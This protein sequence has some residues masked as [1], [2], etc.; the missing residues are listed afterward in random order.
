MIYDS[1]HSRSKSDLVKVIAE[2]PSSS[3]QFST[4]AKDDKRNVDDTN[5]DDT[6]VDKTN[7]YKKN[8]ENS[9]NVAATS[10]DAGNVVV[11]FEPAVTATKS[12]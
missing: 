1:H 10:V 2:K 11:D 3:L 7:V 8:V 5:V 12:K 4:F 9:E 6:N